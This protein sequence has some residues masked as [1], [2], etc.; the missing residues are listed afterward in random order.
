L[1]VGFRRWTRQTSLV[2]QVRGQ[3]FNNRSMHSCH[4]TPLIGW[5]HQT[6]VSQ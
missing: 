3:K 5:G 1:N 6:F 2:V 4:L